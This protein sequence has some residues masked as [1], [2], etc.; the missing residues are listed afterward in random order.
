VLRTFS[1]WAGLAGLRIGYGIFPPKIANY[2]MAIK[3]PYNVS[4]AA[5]IA[6]RES[7]GDLEYLQERVKAVIE[8]R[9]KLFT[10]LLK[11]KWLKPYPSKANFIFCKVLEGDAC[12]VHQKLQRKGILIR[13]FDKPLLRNGIRVSIGKP[14]H[15]ESL[16]KTLSSI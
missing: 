5:I 16:I 4:V 3:M 9:E 8:E 15:T 12:E 6:V 10:E 14:E 7:L 2:L 11:I 13:Y 1:K